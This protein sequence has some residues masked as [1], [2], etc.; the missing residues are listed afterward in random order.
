[1]IQ[2]E[3]VP[4]VAARLRAGLV[5]GSTRQLQRKTNV[6]LRTA[7]QVD[8]DARMAKGSSALNERKNLINC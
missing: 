2:L 4:A 7:Y 3:A 5:L 8:V 1:M 6:H